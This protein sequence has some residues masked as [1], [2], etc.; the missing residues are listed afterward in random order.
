M[1]VTWLD[2]DIS[3]IDTPE[4]AAAKLVGI[5]DSSI[6]HVTIY[7]VLDYRGTEYRVPRYHRRTTKGGDPGRLRH[8]YSQSVQS[9]ARKY[10]YAPFVELVERFLSWSDNPAHQVLRELLPQT[11]H[12]DI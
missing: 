6:Q 7:L 2:E 12:A 10:G 1:K 5:Y 3:P 11:E 8:R 9:F 4:G